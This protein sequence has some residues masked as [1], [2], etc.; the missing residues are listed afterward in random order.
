MAWI[1]SG[2]VINPV[3]DFVLLDTGALFTGSRTPQVIVSSTVASAFELQWRD[4]A[5]AATLKSQIL[6]CPAFDTNDFVLWSGIEMALNER[7]RI[8]QVAAV[9]GSVSVSLF[10]QP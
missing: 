9:T 1:S 4:S 10:Y 6:A 8:V 5:N 3:L 7:L 2:R